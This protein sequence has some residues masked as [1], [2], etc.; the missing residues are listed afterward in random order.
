MLLDVESGPLLQGWPPGSFLA[1]SSSTPLPPPPFPSCES[2]LWP[3]LLEPRLRSTKASSPLPL[4][5]GYPLLP[6]RSSPT[7]PVSHPAG[8]GIFLALLFHR[9]SYFPLSH[10]HHVSTQW[11][12]PG[13]PRAASRRVA[14]PLGSLGPSGRSPAHSQSFSIFL[15]CSPPGFWSQRSFLLF[16]RLFLG[17]RALHSDASWT[18]FQPSPLPH[19]I[20]S[21]PRRCSFSVLDI[22]NGRNQ[23]IPN[24][25]SKRFFI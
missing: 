9:P 21:E 5:H 17:D 1:S 20:A 2:V 23:A 3:S 6:R 18:R 4:G 15:F 10:S 24:V 22:C 12:R 25:C 11:P 19:A 16:C 13:S 8:L 7:C 14:S